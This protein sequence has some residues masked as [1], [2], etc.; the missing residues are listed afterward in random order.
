MTFTDLTHREA[1]DITSLALDV[2]TAAKEVFEIEKYY[3]VAI[4]DYIPHFH[5]HLL[6]KQHTEPSLGP[7]IFGKSGWRGRVSAPISDEEALAC[8]RALRTIIGRGGEW[9]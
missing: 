6:P 4:G 5:F 8:T 7:Y 1:V 3:L 9:R 2:A